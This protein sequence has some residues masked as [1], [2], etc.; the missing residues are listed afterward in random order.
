MT[1]VIEKKPGAEPGGWIKNRIKLEEIEKYLDRGR[2]F[3][4]E[5]AI[6][7]ALAAPAQPEPQRV[8]DILAKSL[9]IETLTP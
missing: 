8:R 1:V 7:R 3:I 9:A 4:D 5:A 2:S 6:A